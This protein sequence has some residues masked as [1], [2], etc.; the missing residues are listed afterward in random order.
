MAIKGIDAAVVRESGDGARARATRHR[1]GLP[2]AR[3][4]CGVSQRYLAEL[5]G[6]RW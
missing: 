5:V 4:P 6:L 3:R 2:T 1:R